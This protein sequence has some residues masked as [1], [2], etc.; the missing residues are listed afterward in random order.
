MLFHL[1]S[2]RGDI[3]YTWKI[4]LSGYAAAYAYE[5]GGLDT[6]MPFPEL[7]HRSHIN[8]QAQAAH[9]AADFSQRI[10][11]GLPRPPPRE[12]FQ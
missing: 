3:R 6:S 8:A 9:A 4:L 12:A 10:R 2:F 1:C 11:A 5:S 7:R